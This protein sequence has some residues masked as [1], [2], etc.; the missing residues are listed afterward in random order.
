VVT[1]IH[2]KYE[3]TIV[4]VLLEL[5]L[6]QEIEAAEASHEV[7]KVLHP[8][9]V[10]TKVDSKAALANQALPRVMMV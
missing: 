10:E 6:K 4:G 3:A 9:L 5:L 8:D 2:V 1:T 7:D